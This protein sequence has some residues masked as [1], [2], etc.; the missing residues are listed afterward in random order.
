M[1]MI[2]KGVPVTTDLTLPQEEM[3]KIVSKLIKDWTWA[4]KELG[5]IE[6]IRDGACILIC[7]YEQP[8]IQ[9][10]PYTL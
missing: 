5:K 3:N 6:L 4:G 10:I 8:S 1:N 9:T 2:I 7:S